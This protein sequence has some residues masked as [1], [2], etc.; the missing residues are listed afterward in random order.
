MS[1]HDDFDVVLF[2]LGGIV[3]ELGGMRD[4]VVFSGEQDEAEIWRR[5]LH[6]PWVQ[7]FERGDCDAQSFARGMVET[8]SMPVGPDE[9]LAAFETW[10]KGLL[11]GAIDL[12]NEV[13][14]KIRVAALSNTNRVHDQRFRDEFRLQDHFEALYLSH[15]IGLVK[16]HR[17]AF[18]FAVEALD[19]APDRVLFL[20]DNQI[21]VDAAREA[22][23]RAELAVRVEGAREALTAHGFF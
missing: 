11:P 10:P 22:G 9:F 19:C 3:I 16:P 14:T 23:L 2:D 18:H 20:D 8:W 4:I 21:N 12:V 5:W 13:A 15:E 1:T 17:E 7:R 6:C